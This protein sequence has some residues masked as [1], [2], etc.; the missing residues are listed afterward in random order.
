MQSRAA[1]VSS[2]MPRDA[3]PLPEF[4]NDAPLSAAPGVPPAL[5]TAAEPNGLLAND[6]EIYTRAMPAS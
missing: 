1:P 6:Q 2:A 3:P 4:T 5:C